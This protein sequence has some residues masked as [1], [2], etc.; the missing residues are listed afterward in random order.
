MQ[1]YILHVLFFCQKE[2]IIYLY[3]RAHAPQLCEFEVMEL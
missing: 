2:Y 3:V 1:N